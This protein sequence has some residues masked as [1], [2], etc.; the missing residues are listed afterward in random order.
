MAEEKKKGFFGKLVS[1]LAKT[2][3]NMLGGVEQVFKGFSKIDEEFYEELEEALIIADLGVHTSMKIIEDLR[4]KVKEK[5]IHEPSE[6]R[7]LLK[8]EII[9]LMTC[10]RRKIRFYS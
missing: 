6:V 2:R 5:K 4:D 9:Q 8:D 1:G 7:E 10:V 3:D